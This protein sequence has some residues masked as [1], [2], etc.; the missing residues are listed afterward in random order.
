MGLFRRRRDNDEAP[1]DMDAVSPVTGLKYKDI[2]VLG[3]LMK[4]GADLT[5][6]RHAI[7]YLYFP[8]REP[9]DAAATSAREVL[10]DVE[11]RAP[12]PEVP[13]WSVVCERHDVVLS[14]DVVIEAD[15]FFQELADTLGGE[16]DGWEASV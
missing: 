3:E 13:Q 15:R 7:Y 1:V 5:E 2:A 14:P 4:H 10:F 11:V 12:R 16:Y 9:A 6:P 8:H